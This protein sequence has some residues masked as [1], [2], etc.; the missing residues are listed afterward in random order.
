MSGEMFLGIIQEDLEGQ[1]LSLNILSD[2]DP[3]CP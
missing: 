1:F 3:S 2:Y